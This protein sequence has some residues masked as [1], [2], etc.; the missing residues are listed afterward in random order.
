MSLLLTMPITWELFELLKLAQD[1]QPLTSVKIYAA[2]ILG[3]RQYV[4][5]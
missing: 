4:G 3:Q 5:C 2:D 1:I